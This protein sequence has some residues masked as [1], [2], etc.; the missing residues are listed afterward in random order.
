M[1]N[2]HS[3]H[4]INFASKAQPK[5][6]SAIYGMMTKSPFFSVFYRSFNV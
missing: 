1:Y 6:D 4:P 2:A 3:H 5:K